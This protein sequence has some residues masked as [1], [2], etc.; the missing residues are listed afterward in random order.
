MAELQ[1][2]S[3]N[4]RGY[5]IYEHDGYRIHISFNSGFEEGEMTWYTDG[6]EPY[7]N[8]ITR[9]KNKKNPTVY[10]IEDRRFKLNGITL[11]ANKDMATLNTWKKLSYKAREGYEDVYIYKQGFSS[12][13]YV[14]NWITSRLRRER[15][16]WE[17][18]HITDIVK[19]NGGCVFT[20]NNTQYYVD[21]YTP[22][23]PLPQNDAAKPLRL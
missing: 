22:P 19:Y 1:N 18:Y 9:I 23:P 15:D 11:N 3:I 8:T 7:T 16:I 13:K 4:E 12:T 14:I 2:P 6:K 21:K 10:D 17:G 20:A 5:I